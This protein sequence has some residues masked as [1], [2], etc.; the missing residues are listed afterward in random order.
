MKEVRHM[1][2]RK[3]TRKKKIRK[4]SRKNKLLKSSLFKAFA[5]I[6]GVLLLVVLAGGLARFLIPP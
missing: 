4:K 6:A 3:T 5:G 1:A 2:K